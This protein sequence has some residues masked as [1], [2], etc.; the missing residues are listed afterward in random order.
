MKFI[1]FCSRRSYERERVDVTLRR[2][3][4]V[5]LAHARSYDVFPTSTP[6]AG[7]R[8]LSTKPTSCSRVLASWLQNS[9]SEAALSI[10]HSLTLEATTFFRLQ[11]HLLALAATKTDLLLTLSGLPGFRI[12]NQKVHC[13]AESTKRT[14]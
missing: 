1:R 6:R 3:D 12:Q 11:F 2:T 8:S 7:A 10:F 9:Q 4:Y 13:V 5:P 14:C